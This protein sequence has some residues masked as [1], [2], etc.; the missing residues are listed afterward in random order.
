MSNVSTNKKEIEQFRKELGDYLDDISKIDIRI[1]NKTLNVTLAQVKFLTPVDSGYM[2]RSWFIEAAHK[3]PWGVEGTIYNIAE[4]ASYVNYGH[5]VKNGSGM[6]VGFVMGKYFLEDAMNFGEKVMVD[7][8][9]KELR[10]VKRKH[11][12]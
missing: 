1:I 3:G 4:Y 11:E 9:K 10:R 2:R 7:E 5:R 12:Q 8:F 6:T